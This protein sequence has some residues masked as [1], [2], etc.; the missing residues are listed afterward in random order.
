MKRAGLLLLL[1]LP[2]LTGM[3]KPLLPAEGE[4][5][6]VRTF[7]SG[8]IENWEVSIDNQDG[9][10]EAYMM[11][12]PNRWTFEVGDLTGEV[13]TE[14]NDT[15]NSWI[16][17]A[18]SQTYKLKTW[19][20]NSWQKWELSGGDITGKVTIQTLYHASWD[21][22]TMKPDG[23]TESEMDI[24]TLSN[25]SWDDWTLRGD[26]SKLTAGEKAAAFFIPVFVSRIYKRGL[27]K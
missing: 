19:L 24:A 16:I 11:N 23:S 21:N 2:L 26:A 15:Y 25:N 17:T 20:T 13:N 1:I 5:G 18:G 10:L 22:W 12:D 3:Q 27:V 7:F 8:K 4:E 14:F 9:N 6:R